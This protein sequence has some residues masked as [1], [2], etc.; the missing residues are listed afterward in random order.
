M[1]RV[2]RRYALIA[3]TLLLVNVLPI[4]AQVRSMEMSVGLSGGV[5]KYYGEYTDDVFGALGEF[6]VTFS[7]IRHMTLGLQTTVGQV[8]WKVTPATMSKFPAYFGQNARIGGLY[9]GT[10]A[11][12]EEFSQSRISLYDFTITANLLPDE[13]IVPFVGAGIGVMTWSPTN[14]EQHTQLPN[15]ANGVYDRFDFQFPLI[16]GLHIYMTEDLAFTARASYRI[17]LTPYIDDIKTEA[18]GNDH[19]ATLSAGLTYHFTGNRDPDEDGLNTEREKDLGTDPRQADTD[20]DGLRDGDEIVQYKTDPLRSDTDVDGLRDGE[21]IMDHGTNPLLPDTDGDGLPDGVE[22]M[23]HRTDPVNVDSD[24]DRLFDGEEVLRHK[25]NP[26]NRDTD[27]DGVDDPDELSCRYQTNPL[28]PDTDGDGIID[29]M[30][31]EPA[32]KCIGCGGGGNIAPY[33]TPQQPPPPPPAP[34]PEPAPTPKAEPKPEPKPEPAPEPAATPKKRMSFSKDIRFIVD[35]DEFD[36][37]QPE[38]QK[39][40]QEL[41]TYMQNSCDDLQ[42]MLEGHA[43]SDG[44]PQRNK[45]LSDLRARKVREWLLKQGVSPSK[46]RGAIGYGSSMPRVKEPTARDMKRMSKEEQESLRRQNR[47]IEVAVLKDC[48]TG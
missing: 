18:G 19:L 33:Q 22:V 2:K 14:F 16:A 48:P 40:L 10:L 21:E 36:M 38:T 12:I 11:E 46:I 45:E 30:D 41:L 39:N 17:T 9:P 34:A 25:T 32:L 26:L 31:P 42:V 37:T 5:A 3:V 6:G 20:H 8:I 4:S 13:R 44:P 28:K 24:N 35:T 23:S 29:S 43:S 7:P 27:F 15:N 1:I 47:R